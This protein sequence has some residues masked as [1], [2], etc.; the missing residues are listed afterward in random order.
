M[1][2]IIGVHKSTLIRWLLSG[3]V[4]E[5]KRNRVAGMGFRVWLERDVEKVR[6]HKEKNYRKG[7][8]RKAKTKK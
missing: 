6:K 7:R 3:V 8:G 2:K 1:A 5:P 4:E